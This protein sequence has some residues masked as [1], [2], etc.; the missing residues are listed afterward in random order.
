MILEKLN[1]KIEKLKTKIKPSVTKSILSDPDVLAYLARLHEKYVI[2]PVDQASNDWTD[3]ICKKFY[4]SKIFS[5]V[6]E[7]NKI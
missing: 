7:Y 6:D 2:I 3:F 5:E 1:L 4:I